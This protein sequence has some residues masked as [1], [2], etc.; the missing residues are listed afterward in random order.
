MK[1]LI[2]INSLKY[3]GAEKQVVADAN[4][5]SQN[6][7]KI[8]I[9]YNQF[10]DLGKLLND[11]IIQYRI[12]RKNEILASFQLFIHLLFNK[13]DIIHSHMFWAEKVSSLSG[14]LTGHKVIFNEHGLVLLVDLIKSNILQFGV[15]DDFSWNKIS[16]KTIEVYSL[17]IKDY[18]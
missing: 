18:N 11:K 9:A 1:F 15:N 2:I 7:Y 17:S 16:E 4:P 8:T 6:G 5:L 12:K 3:S 13:Y 10:G 14:K